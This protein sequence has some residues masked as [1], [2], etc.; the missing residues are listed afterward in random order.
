[1]TKTQRIILWV[2]WPI[3]LLAAS[4]LL[5][6]LLVP[7]AGERVPLEDTSLQNLMGY[8]GVN[9]A[10]FLAWALPLIV[11]LF[12]I[13]WSWGYAIYIAIKVCK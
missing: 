9:K 6:S 11:S 8:D 12:A 2:L 4:I 3:A 10:L 1:M 5:S 13:P 7:I